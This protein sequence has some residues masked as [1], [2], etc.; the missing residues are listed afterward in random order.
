MTLSEA[1]V[2]LAVSA[3]TLRQQALKVPQVLRAKKVG[4]QWTITRQE[5]ERYRRD[6][7]GKTGR[8]K[9]KKKSR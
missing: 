6:H 4:N 7:L 5:L 2:E 8:P 3:D 1:A 9:G